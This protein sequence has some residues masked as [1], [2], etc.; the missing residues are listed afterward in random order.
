MGRCCSLSTGST[1]RNPRPTCTHHHPYCRSLTL[2]HTLYKHLYA[3]YIIATTDLFLCSS[4]SYPC[5]SNP[6]STLYTHKAVFVCIIYI[7]Y[8]VSIYIMYFYHMH[9]VYNT[10]CFPSSSATQPPIPP[11]LSPP[12]RHQAD[13]SPLMCRGS[14]V[15][16][17]LT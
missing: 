4:C 8:D 9:A 10:Y 16:S 13:G 3:I 15:G 11:F 12:G 1:S 6:M 5:N 2:P 7:P 17:F 14:S